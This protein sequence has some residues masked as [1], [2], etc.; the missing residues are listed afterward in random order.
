[1]CGVTVTV[2]R[3]AVARSETPPRNYGRMRCPWAMRGEAEVPF[4][5]SRLVG[6][7]RDLNLPD[8]GQEIG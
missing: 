2:S 6:W 8:V 7:L 4:S 3:R 1:M 5:G